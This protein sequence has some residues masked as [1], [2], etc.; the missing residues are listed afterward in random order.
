[1]CI[2]RPWRGAACSHDHEVFNAGSFM[3]AQLG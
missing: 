1:M 2:L 3:L